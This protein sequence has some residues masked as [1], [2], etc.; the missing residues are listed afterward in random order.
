MD[1]TRLPLLPLILHHVPWAFRQVLLQEGIPYRMYGPGPPQGRFLIFDSRSQPS[2]IVA[3]GQVVL[4]LAEFRRQFSQDP[5]EALED[6]GAERLGWQ[7]G[8]WRLE[9]EAARVNKRRVREELM[10]R[11]RGWVESQGGLWLRVAPFP[12]PYRSAF[13][14][15]IDHEDYQPEDFQS[16]LDALAGQESTTSHFLAAGAFR[17]APEAL[18]RL[19][20]LDV[21]LHGYRYHTYGT[22][23]E[24]WVNIRRG[25]ELL[26]QAGLEPIG[27]AG[28]D[29]RW[30]RSLLAA[31]E[32]LGFAY[33]SEVG[34]AYDELPF[35][36][37]ESEVLQIPVHPIGLHLF[38]VA[39][40]RASQDHPQQKPDLLRSAQE[41]AGNYFCRL[42]ETCTLAGEPILL[43]GRV[44]GYLGRYPQLL[45]S[46]LAA[47]SQYGSL[48]RSTLSEIYRWWQV[49]SKVYVTV[50]AAGEGYEVHTHRKPAGFRVAVELW[51]GAHVAVVPLDGPRRS[52]QLGALAFEKR[53]AAA[54]LSPVRI[55]PPEGL[56]ERL[57]RWWDRYRRILPEER[58]QEPLAD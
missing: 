48:W 40:Q 17:L 20:G 35:Y 42:L 25:K 32:K 38:L 27:F 1:G 49:R 30:N 44:T 16:T 14:L 2:A 15:R 33:S 22:E 11:L 45:R 23:E 24:N 29:G 3:P 51:R 10:D 56:R 18:Q 54:R 28:P 46:V 31:L 50:Y 47:A 12:F 4:D 37:P 34:L 43:H 21:G 52:L 53:P 6:V 7:V 41:T 57:R 19:R 5:L 8:P 55:D 58:T 36:P 13:C 26:A 9:T 39:A